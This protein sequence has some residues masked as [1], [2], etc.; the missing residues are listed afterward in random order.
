MPQ[1]AVHV[2]AINKVYGRMVAIDDL[3][4]DVELGEIIEQDLWLL[5]VVQHAAHSAVNRD[6]IPSVVRRA[7]GKNRA[8]PSATGRSDAD[9]LR[10]GNRPTRLSRA[11]RVSRRRSHAA[12]RGFWHR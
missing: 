4:F 8:A 5:K 9:V 10:S 6:A 3:S 2:A 7:P 11:A 12:C 1:P